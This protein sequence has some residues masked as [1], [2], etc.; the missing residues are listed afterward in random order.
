MTK[1]NNSPL[2]EFK[3]RFGTWKKYNAVKNN[4]Q[5][6]FC[7][8]EPTHRMFIPKI[9]HHIW[10]QGEDK[11][12]QEL[13]RLR[14]TWRNSFG[15]EYL[16]YLWDE[17]S[18]DFLMRQ[19]YS[20]FYKSWKSLPYM[21]QKI[22]SAKLFILDHMGG[23]YIDMD[24][25]CISPIKYLLL[26]Y[27]LVF[28]EHDSNYAL[29][30]I[31]KDLGMEGFYKYYLNNAFIASI[32]QH[33][34]IFQMLNRLP[35]TIQ[36]PE[37]GYQG[38]WIGKTCGTEVI[39]SVLLDNQ[40]DLKKYGVKIYSYKIM[41]CPL[42]KKNSNTRILHHYKSYWNFQSQQFQ[43]AKS[44]AFLGIVL[45]TSVAVFSFIGVLIHKKKIKMF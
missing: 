14:Q 31:A 9:V 24:M 34:L 11:I 7:V 22:D 38:M 20:W 44:G 12:P 16:F 10:F 6:D 45:L 3:K 18:I 26:D 37:K 21:I 8:R 27:K 33:P 36:I 40:N 42:K 28:S 4:E 30:F 13:N 17:K 35:K 23:I 25:E 41:D 1:R 15:K 32:P 29:R 5:Q 43:L 19:K 39:C 2:N